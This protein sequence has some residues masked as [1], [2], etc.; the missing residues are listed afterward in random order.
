MR[1]RGLMDPRLPCAFGEICTADIGPRRTCFSRLFVPNKCDF[2]MNQKPTA[3][4]YAISQQLT[5]E[6]G[7]IPPACLETYR[8][9]GLRPRFRVSHKP[10]TVG[11]P[12]QDSAGGRTAAPPRLSTTVFREGKYIRRL[13]FKTLSLLADALLRDVLTTS[14]SASGPPPNFPRGGPTACQLYSYRNGNEFTCY[15]RYLAAGAEG[16]RRTLKG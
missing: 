9:C 5:G 6:T 8:S 1:A 7:R 15:F 10:S 4:A 14:A 12:V 16:R 13:L 11:R 2:A 3:P